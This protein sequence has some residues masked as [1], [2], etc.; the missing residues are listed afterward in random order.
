[1]RCSGADLQLNSADTSE[2][3]QRLVALV[4]TLAGP[5]P[6]FAGSCVAASICV[7]DCLKVLC[8]AWIH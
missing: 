6:S 7:D 3:V 5:A 8:Q 2:Q 4:R 1:M